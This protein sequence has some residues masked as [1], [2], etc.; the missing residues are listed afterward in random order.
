M[1]TEEKINK[2]AKELYDWQRLFLQYKPSH[3]TNPKRTER[4]LRECAK[5]ILRA[6]NEY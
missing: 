5:D 2:I 6:I 1:D 4:V 3:W